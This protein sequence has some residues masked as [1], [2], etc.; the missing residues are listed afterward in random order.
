MDHTHSDEND[1]LVTIVEYARLEEAIVARSILEA[2]GIDV[3][4]ADENFAWVA[5]RGMSIRLQVHE[6][7]A[8]E[9]LKILNSSTAE[10]L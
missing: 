5:H 9:A 8:A 7:D 1:K 6:S 10:S 2:A 3:F 4:L